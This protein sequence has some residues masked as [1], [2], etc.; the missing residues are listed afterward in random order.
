MH[1]ASALQVA[2]VLYKFSHFI[3]QLLEIAS[4]RHMVLATHNVLLVL[5][6]QLPTHVPCVSEIWFHTHSLSALHCEALV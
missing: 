3:E 2:C 1:L 5:P 6:A 4:Q